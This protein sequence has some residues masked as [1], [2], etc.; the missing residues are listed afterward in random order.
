MYAVTIQ[1][2]LLTMSASF[3]L[4]GMITFTAGLFIL[5]TRVTGQNVRAI[6]DQTAQLAQ[7]GLAEDIAGLVGNANA[8][9]NTMAEMVRT[10][11]GVGV[12]LSISGTTMMGAGFWV[13]L[14]IR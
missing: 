4:L 7:K 12:F 13:L 6:S 5:F 3:F 9:L 1:D 14:Q 8:L 11:A 2:V 10:A